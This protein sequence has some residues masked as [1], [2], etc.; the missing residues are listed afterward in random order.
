MKSLNWASGLIPLGR[1][2]LRPLQLH[3]HSLGLTNRFTPL[4]CSDPLA[5]AN[6]LRQW[7]DLS[8]LTSVILIRPFQ[9]EFTTLLR[10][11]P[12]WGI[13]RF[14]VLGPVQTAS[15]TSTVWSSSNFGPPSLEFSFFHS[16]WHLWYISHKIMA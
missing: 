2:H 14:H 13:P 16:G 12:I 7:Q 8:F 3:F 11:L 4:L 6:R 10:P 1:L 15:S 5:L 9:A